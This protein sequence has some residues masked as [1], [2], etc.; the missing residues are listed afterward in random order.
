MP[1]VFQDHILDT[2]PEGMHRIIEFCIE[3]NVNP[4]LIPDLSHR[5]FVNDG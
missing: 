1:P 2:L 5:Q 3:N 4:K